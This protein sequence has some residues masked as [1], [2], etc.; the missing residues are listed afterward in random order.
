MTILIT[1]VAGFIGAHLCRALRA[2]GRSL[3]GVDAFSHYY[4]PALKRDRLASLC[5]GFEPIVLDLADRA[6]CETLFRDLRP[7]RVIH[8]AAQPGVR[9]ALHAPHDYADANLIGFL[10]VLEGCRRTGSEHL[11]YA[12]SSSV[13]GAAAR[14]PF[15]EGQRIDQ[16]L[17]L[18]AASKAANELMAYSYG[19][20]HGLVS[21]GLRLFTVYGPWGRPDMA[22]V[23]FAR[24]VLAGQPIEVYNHGRMRRDFTHVDDI[25]AG[26]IAALDHPPGHAG[27]MPGD[28]GERDRI[29][30]HR[31]FNL[32][33]HRPVELERFITIIEQAAG[34]RALRRDRPLQVGDM[35]ETLADISAA[36]EHLGYQPQITIEQGLPGVVEWCRDY[37]RHE[38]AA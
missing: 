22:P 21:T 31:V 3:V 19:H 30:P 2:A 38:H 28:D 36:R 33:N 34:R 5:P 17:S 24:A 1:G 6:A 32:G 35:I 9:H 20:S 12:S 10:N 14:A 27:D 13:Y 25:V 29:V 15:S 4:D 11:I 18:Y 26:I 7:S 37:Y 16:P 8:L 23:L